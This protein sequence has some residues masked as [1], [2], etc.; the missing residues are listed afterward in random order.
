MIRDNPKLNDLDL[1]HLCPA[2][3]PADALK[4]QKKYSFN[5]L[6]AT[7][8]FTP[9]QLTQAEAAG[10]GTPVPLTAPTGPAKK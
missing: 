2:L 9:A 6:K 3:Y 5:K 8:K 7:E 1:A 4:D 10:C